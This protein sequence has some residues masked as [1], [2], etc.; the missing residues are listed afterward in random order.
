M[1][2]PPGALPEPQFLAGCTRKN[3]CAAACPVDAIT[4]VQEGPGAGTP[5]IRAAER[6]CVSCTDTP[7][8]TACGPGVL[9][10]SRGVKMGTARI[11]PSACVAYRGVV[12]TSCVNRCPVP[13][14]ME[15]AYG[16]PRILEAACT[17]CGVCHEVCPAP[18]NAV[19]LFPGID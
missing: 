2:R 17:G 18:R 7:C 1:H 12:C 9:T 4:P 5:Q 14:A 15:L 11:A 16:R 19:L 8:I 10:L 13:G 6:A 3:D